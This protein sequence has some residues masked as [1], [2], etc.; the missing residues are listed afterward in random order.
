LRRL[1]IDEA[2]CI[3]VSSKL[4]MVIK[5]LTHSQEWGSSFRPVRVV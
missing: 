4:L 1:V 2:H 3:S 5:T